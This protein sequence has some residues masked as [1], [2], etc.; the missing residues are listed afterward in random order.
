MFWDIPEPGKAR[1]ILMGKLTEWRE[2]FQQQKIATSVEK[3][4]ERTI[5]QQPVTETIADKLEK[6]KKLLDIG[7]ITKEEYEKAKQKLLE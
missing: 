3:M 7:A 1:E 4:T 2:V 5:P 6:L